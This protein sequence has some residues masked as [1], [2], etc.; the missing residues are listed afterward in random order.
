MFILPTVEIWTA[1]AGGSFSAGPTM[2]GARHSHTA[3]RL[4]TG[5]VLVAGGGNGAAASIPSAMVYVPSMPGWVA[6]DAMN[7]D[8]AYHVAVTLRTGHVILGGGCNPSTCMPW[9]EVYDPAT[10]SLHRVDGGAPWPADGGLDSSVEPDA[11][12]VFPTEPPHPAGYRIGA[13]LCATSTA[14]GLPCPLA[15]FPRQDADYVPGTHPLMLSASGE[16]SDG[17]TGLSWQAADDGSTYDLEHAVQRCA[18]LEP[19]GTWRLPSVIELASIVN[20]GMNSPALDPV[21]VGA[22]STNYWSTTPVSS[23]V[24]QNWTV[25][26]DFGEVIPM[27]A[28]HALSVRCVHGGPSPGGAA[29]HVRQA[30]TFVATGATV[31]DE[32][33]GLEWQRTDDG[34]RRD[35]Q[36]ALGYCAHLDLGGHTD[37]HL[38]NVAELRGIVEYGGTPAG[39]AVIDPVFTDARPDLYWSSTPND[40]APTLSWSVSF[41]L[42]VVDGVTTSGITYGRCVRHIRA[43]PP[44]PQSSCACG[45]GERSLRWPIEGLARLLLLVA[46]RRRRAR[47]VSPHR[48][49]PDR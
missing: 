24:E 19:V 40:G 7:M 37:W 9:A 20:Y 14:Q 44:P 32:T 5:E 36:G 35:W 42:G 27:G 33:T 49:H 34:V 46:A 2:L 41:N 8:R 1:A 11:G 23:G 38:A 13:S 12:A 47:F 28:S 26:F 48:A 22:Q 18:A 25:R 45:V 31:R 3:T 15:G 10:L 43:A 21:F 39:T 4:E 6:I 29:G 16:V 17:T 30:G